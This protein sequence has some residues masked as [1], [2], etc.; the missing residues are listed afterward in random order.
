MLRIALAVFLALTVPATAQV[1]GAIGPASPMLKRSVTVASD[2][3]RIGDLIDNA[4]P[5]AQ[6]AI[7][8]APDL[9]GTG[10]VPTQRVLEAARA[11]NVLGVNTGGVSEVTV[12]HA[13]RAITA[14][15]IEER[16][17]QAVA[18]QLGLSGSGDVLVKLDREVRTLHVEATATAS[19]QVARLSHDAR[20]GHF[21]VLLDLPGSA[22]ARR[23]PLRFSGTA[24]EMM[25]VAKL[26][27]PLTRGEIVRRSDIVMERRPKAELGTD[28][29]SDP[30]RVMDLSVRR[31]MRAGQMLRQADLMKPELVQRNEA[32]TLIFE[33][34]GIVLTSRGKAL[35]TGAEGD[36]IGVLN[37]QSKRTVQGTVTGFGTVAVTSMTP[38][39][40][41]NLVSPETA[42]HA[43]S[44]Y[45]RTE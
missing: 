3:V 30:E 16:I 15:E 1:I 41:S 39:I 36:V 12:M 45:S 32:V 33:A 5:A 17:A 37:V 25:Q 43:A 24:V 6:I 18:G 44:H 34:P 27:R 29:V 14:K 31:T 23:L 38:R 42:G 9:G 20:S 28:V 19:L 13:S 11:H 8:R 40:A 2:V 22:T 21:D 4:G 26:A 35:E 7:F 10:S